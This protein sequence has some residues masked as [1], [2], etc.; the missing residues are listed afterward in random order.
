M[1]FNEAT[2]VRM[3]TGFSCTQRY[4][5]RCNKNCAALDFPKIKDDRE[6]GMTTLRIPALFV[7]MPLE[8]PYLRPS[9]TVAGPG[10]RS[11][12]CTLPMPFYARPG[13]CGI[14]LGSTMIIHSTIVILF[15]ELYLRCKSECLHQSLA[16]VSSLSYKTVPRGIRIASF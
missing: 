13:P 11:Y 10:D 15:F 14:L 16:Y 2:L 3:N 5:L 8:P 12:S 1:D 9:G 4:F 7:D 6:L